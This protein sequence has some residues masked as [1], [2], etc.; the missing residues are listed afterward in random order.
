M[1]GVHKSEDRCLQMPTAPLRLQLVPTYG[2]HG[3]NRSSQVPTGGM[4]QLVIKSANFCLPFL[5]SSWNLLNI[6]NIY[7]LVMVYFSL[8]GHTEIT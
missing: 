8:Y 4:C 1:K 7:Y 6:A 2:R 3:T 5:V